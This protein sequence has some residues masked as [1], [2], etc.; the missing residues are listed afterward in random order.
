MYQDTLTSY[1]S[2]NDS[3]VTQLLNST[4]KAGFLRSRQDSLSRNF[5]ISL[6]LSEAE[7]T[8]LYSL[9]TTY[10]QSLYPTD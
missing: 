3:Y 1:K 7:A 9:Y 2:V 8:S 10:H 5:A 6:A 4:D